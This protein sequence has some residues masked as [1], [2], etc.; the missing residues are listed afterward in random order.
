MQN[1]RIIRQ[2]FLFLKEFHIFGSYGNFDFSL[3][4]IVLIS[5]SLLSGSA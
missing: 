5:E 3:Q 2:K 4:T 1:F